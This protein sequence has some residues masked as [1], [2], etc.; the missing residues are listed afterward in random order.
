MKHFHVIS[1]RPASGT[2]MDTVDMVMGFVIAILTAIKPML[3]IIDDKPAT[4]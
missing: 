3:S 1:R 2:T 4:T